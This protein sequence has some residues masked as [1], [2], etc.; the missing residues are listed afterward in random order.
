MITNADP[1]MRK[2]LVRLTRLRC[3]LKPIY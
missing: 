1:T 3:G 2:S